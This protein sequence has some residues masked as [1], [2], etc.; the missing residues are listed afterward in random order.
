MLSPIAPSYH[1]KW[2]IRQQTKALFIKW[3]GEFDLAM[4]PAA[5]KFGP[6]FPFRVRW[7]RGSSK[8]VFRVLFGLC[9]ERARFASDPSQIRTIAVNLYIRPPIWKIGSAEALDRSRLRPLKESLNLLPE[10]YAARMRALQ[11]REW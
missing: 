9:N 11:R 4:R 8:S 7:D 1:P 6:N 2:Y 3:M 10:E 5:A